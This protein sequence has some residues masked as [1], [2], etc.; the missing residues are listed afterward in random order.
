[1]KRLLIFL[2]LLA[3]IVG[4]SQ[5]LSRTFI[6]SPSGME[7]N[8]RIG[9]YSVTKWMKVPRILTTLPASDSAG[10]GQIAFDSANTRTMWYHNGI[11]WVQ[12]GSGGGGSGTVTS[13][14]A[15]YGLNGGTIT[16]AGTV[17]VDTTRIVNRRMLD[18]VANEIPVDYIDSAR[19]ADTAA[20][21]RGAI[22]STSGF[23]PY[24]GA[25]DS[26]RLGEYPIRAGQFNLD[27]TPTAPTVVGG[28][29]W[30]ATNECPAMPFDATYTHRFGQ[31]I[32]ERARNNTGTTISA[33]KVVY[34]SGAQ[35][36]NPTITMA[37]PDSVN[38]SRV[39]G[40]TVESIADNATGFVMVTGKLDGINTS[41]FTV[42]A[43]L[44]LDTTTGGLTQ[45]LLPSPHNVVY[46]GQ[47]LNSTNNGRIFVRPA[48]PLGSDTTL[49]NASQQIAPTQQAVKKY[50]TTAISGK[51]NYSDTTT[52]DATRSYVNARVTDTTSLSN[53]INTK[54][55]FTDTTT[56]DATR[57]WVAGQIPSLTGYQLYSDTSTFDATR[58]WVTSR[59]YG[60]GTVTSVGSGFGLSGGAITTTGT[61]RVDTA[62]VPTQY[63]VDTTAANALA[64]I[65]TKGSGTVTSVAGGF[66]LTGGTI[67]TSGTLAVDTTGVIATQ[68]D[69]NLAIRD[70]TALSNRISLLNTVQG[71]NVASADTI[72]LLTTTGNYVNVTG[73]TTIRGLSPSASANASI[74]G[75]RRVVNFNG[76]LT[77]TH[78]AT[79]LQLPGGAN[80]TTVAGD[81]AEFVYLG[82]VSWVC[83]NYTKRTWTGTGSVMLAASPS[84]T[85]T[86]T[87]AAITASGTISM[88]GGT[89]TLGSSTGASTVGLGTGATTT[90]NT[91][92]INIGGAAASGSTQNINIGSTAASGST[93]AIVIGSTAATNT[94]TVNGTTTLQG[95]VNV[96]GT[97]SVTGTAAFTSTVTATTAAASDSTTNVATTAFVNSRIQTIT[98]TNFTTSYTINSGNKYNVQLNVT[99]QAGA[100]LFNNPTGT[101]VNNQMILG[102]VQDNGSN[103][104]ITWD[105]K[106]VG[107]NG[108]TLPSTTTTGRPLIFV[109]LYNS[110]QDKYYVSLL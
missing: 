3:P 25:T 77:L 46:I 107:A 97:M 101:W 67:T 28:M 39:I 7:Y 78:N 99:A 58:S 42:G 44:Y 70:T 100:L 20:A 105:T 23:V 75:A 10:G 17:S 56:W 30:D 95:T 93:Q 90:G 26:V 96:T 72:N 45:A 84:T 33:G 54:Q 2:L 15:G 68:A 79:T 108:S 29:Y 1:M 76:A 50:V 49:G 89:V 8:T 103:R 98:T 64:R 88:T 59:G 19:L 60:T 61:L 81:C 55:N 6:G 57:S 37:N 27:L 63:R 71:A 31:A 9:G 69:V 16:N 13:I 104:A 36:N 43:A 87:A 66:G 34:I 41:G 85:G 48:M 4:Y 24:T 53:R 21:I 47:A 65:N 92:T 102:S 80:I 106:W 12:F 110:F 83:I 73:T 5:S 91:K 94:V 38:S 109:A 14:T 51:Q 62:N 86:L 74:I 18:S 35:G 82:G 11:Q 52:W 40:V 32:V 22:P